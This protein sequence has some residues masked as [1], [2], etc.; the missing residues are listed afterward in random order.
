MPRRVEEGALYKVEWAVMMK[1]NEVECLEESIDLLRIVETMIDS[2][3]AAEDGR[4]GSESSKAADSHAPWRGIKR[5]LITVRANLS[6]LRRAQDEG[7]RQTA[8]HSPSSEVVPS[9]EASGRAHGVVP[10]R[11]R[12]AAHYGN[13]GAAAERG[14]R[15]GRPSGG[16]SLT[17]RIQ[18]A[19]TAGADRQHSEERAERNENPDRHSAADRQGGRG[20]TREIRRPEEPEMDAGATVPA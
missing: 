2:C 14:A 12:P 5:T 11:D 4:A 6:S 20:S 19:P 9:A 3:A 18:M 16:S 8:D 7:F 1:R 17:S 13:E 10:D 15:G